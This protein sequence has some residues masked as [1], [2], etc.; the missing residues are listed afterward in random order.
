TRG[1]RA[2]RT[3]GARGAAARTGGRSPPVPPPTS[4]TA[5][6]SASGTAA[7]NGSPIG[8]ITGD[9]RRAYSSALAA[10][11]ATRARVGCPFATPALLGGL[12]FNSARREAI[13]D[14]MGVALLEGQRDDAGR[15][16]P[17]T[18]DLGQPEF[19]AEREVD[20][21]SMRRPG[22]RVA[23]RLHDAVEHVRDAQRRRPLWYVDLEADRFEERLVIRR[24]HRPVD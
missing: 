9:H 18:G 1:T 5:V 24:A 11:A 12:R 8:L 20:A 10:Y 14:K 19:L 3:S 4:R 16:R 17:A 7:T 13:V 15:A 2:V 23:D 6:A 21:G 22:D